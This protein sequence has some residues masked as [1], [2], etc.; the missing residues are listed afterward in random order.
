M[1]IFVRSN[2]KAQWKGIVLRIEKRKRISDLYTV[3]ILKDANGNTPRKRIL[4]V[5]D[6]GWTEK[7]P[8]MET[9]HIN[10]DWFK[11]EDK[12]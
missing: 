6:S 1:K 11:L 2:Y 8:E 12:H 3:L 9:E 5:L 4:S 10:K 7:V